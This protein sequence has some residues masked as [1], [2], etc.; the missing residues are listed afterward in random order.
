M[1]YRNCT[2]KLGL[3]RQTRKHSKG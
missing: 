2:N 3:V 1:K